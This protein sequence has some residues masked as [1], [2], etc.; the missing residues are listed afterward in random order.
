MPVAMPGQW[1]VP[2]SHFP[3]GSYNSFASGPEFN[4]VNVIQTEWCVSRTYYLEG[5]LPLSSASALRVKID[6]SGQGEQNG[7]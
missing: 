2:P 7:I 4:C 3:F 6:D 1:A 5:N